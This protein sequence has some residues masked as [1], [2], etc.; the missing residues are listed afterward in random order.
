MVV[1]VGHACEDRDEVHLRLDLCPTLLAE[2][3]EAPTLSTTAQRAGKRHLLSHI[4]TS[5]SRGVPTNPVLD[6]LY[7]NCCWMMQAYV[8]VFHTPNLG[9]VPSQRAFSLP[10]PEGCV[11]P[12]THSLVFTT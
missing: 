8:C 6:S 12:E 5:A 7:Q 11:P 2:P 3:F 10:V 1:R 4:S 9:A